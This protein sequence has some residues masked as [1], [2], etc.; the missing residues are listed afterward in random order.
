MPRRRRTVAIGLLG[1]TLDRGKDAAR[2]EAW[3]PTVALCQHEDLLI[4][5]FEL[6]HQQRFQSLAGTV[7]ADIQHV[8]PETE[9]RLHAVETRDPW[10]FEDV[11]AALHDFCARIPVRP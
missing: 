5:R 1:P 4:D 2:W 7:R 9:V 6:M 3:R 11:Y 8:S 10:D